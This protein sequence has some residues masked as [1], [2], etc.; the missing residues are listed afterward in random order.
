MDIISNL[1]KLVDAL[2]SGKFKRG[3]SSMKYTKDNTILYCPL[4]VA[5]EVFANHNGDWTWNET[6]SGI[7]GF[8][9]TKNE[10]DYGRA[11]FVPK[12]VADFFGFDTQLSNDIT[13]WNDYDNYSFGQI[14]EFIEMRVKI[15]KEKLHE[16][17]TKS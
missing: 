2:K 3:R 10:G 6:G 16:H 5:C 1:G 8:Y 17:S 12:E 13:R 4:G 7:Y 14:A 9:N 11:A 15:K